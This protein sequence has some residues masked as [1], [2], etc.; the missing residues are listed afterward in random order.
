MSET[1]PRAVSVGVLKG[2]FGK[3]TT[4][5]NTAREL[6]HRN[7]S[8][9]VIDLDDNGHMTRQLGFEDEFTSG[10]NHT[11]RVLVD[12]EEPIQYITNV[13]DGLD[14]FPAHTELE[15]VENELR[16][17]TMG[18][19]RLRKHLVDPLLGDEYD[20]I[21]VDCPAN[22]GKLNDNAMY[23]TRNIIIPL[24]PESGYDSGLSNTIQRLVEEAREYFELNILA[25][26]PTALNSRID[27]DTRDRG[28]LEQLNSLD[29]ADEIIPSYARI[30][31]EEWDAI[32]VGE[33]EGG[34]PGIRFRGA[35][36]AAHDAALPVRDYDESC[37]QLENYAELAQ[38][39]EQG[40][41]DR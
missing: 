15:S 30:T 4:A 24:K 32:D 37:D 26:T 31:H 27:Q 9:L 7:G 11:Q 5:I 36:D 18:S 10:V 1:E 2:G 25:V 21:V 12:S 35:I 23:A 13:V 14:L 38:I 20:Y 40:G 3:T 41:I 6:A 33:Y 34:L 28:L 39:V 17:A 8:A 22:R 19:A 29:I 16:N